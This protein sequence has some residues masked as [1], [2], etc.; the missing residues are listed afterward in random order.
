[1]TDELLPNED[2]ERTEARRKFLK[3]ASQVA[4]TTP[5]AVTLIL[6]AA[7]KRAKAGT[8]GSNGSGGSIL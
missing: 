8:N 6:A 1:M 2:E 4:V 3:L 7:T 5:A